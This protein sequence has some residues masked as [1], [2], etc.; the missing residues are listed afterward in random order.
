[1]ILA[2]YKNQQRANGTTSRTT[3]FDEAECSLVANLSLNFVF[4]KSVE[5]LEVATEREDFLAPRLTGNSFYKLN[6]TA[7]KSH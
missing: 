7:L 6:Y 5:R 4:P 1:M 2:I 3:H